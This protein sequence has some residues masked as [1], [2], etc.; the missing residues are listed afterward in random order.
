MKLKEKHLIQKEV[1]QY[2]GAM[3][4]LRDAVGRAQAPQEMLAADYGH[5]GLQKNSQEV[6]GQNVLPVDQ[7]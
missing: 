3:D 6:E 5:F 1:R 4:G 7:E 2:I